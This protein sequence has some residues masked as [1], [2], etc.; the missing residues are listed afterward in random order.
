MWNRYYNAGERPT[1]VILHRRPEL[2]HRVKL[3]FGVHM[4]MRELYDST[5]WPDWRRK[6]DTIHLLINHRSYLDPHFKQFPDF[7]EHNIQRYPYMF[8]QLARL[9]LPAQLSSQKEKEI[10]LA[11]QEK[12]QPSY[13]DD[14]KLHIIPCLLSIFDTL[15]F[16]CLLTQMIQSISI[17]L[18]LHLCTAFFVSFAGNPPQNCD[19]ISSLSSHKFHVMSCIANVGV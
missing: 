10:D 15:L 8:G 3:K 11:K 19:R 16:F 7:D 6:Q 5:E 17:Y 9:V 1:T 2:I 4:L 18:V 12:S 14:W 13:L